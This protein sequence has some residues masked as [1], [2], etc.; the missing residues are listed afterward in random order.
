MTKKSVQIKVV[1]RK[2]GTSAP[3]SA[4]RIAEL[5]SLVAKPIDTSDIPEIAGRVRRIVRDASGNL[6][7][8]KEGPTRRLIRE[9]LGRLSM[10]R[11]TL[12]KQANKYCP[13]LTA[14]A[15]YEYL[16]GN[17]DITSTYLEALLQAAKIEL[18]ASVGSPKHTKA[19]PKAAQG[20]AN[21]E[22]KAS[23]SS[24]TLQKKSPIK[25]K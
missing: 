3:P 21:R 2:A 8:I 6:P 19:A 13:T 18:S 20:V 15:V 12:W 25:V 14:S 1:R 10:T 7:A 24:K 17:R 16:A 5:R 23:R 4:K 11:Y 9:Q 22:P